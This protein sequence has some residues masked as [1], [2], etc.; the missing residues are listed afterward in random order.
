MIFNILYCAIFALVLIN[1]NGHSVQ[2]AISAEQ[3]QS[4]ETLYSDKDSISIQETIIYDDEKHPLILVQDSAIVKYYMLDGTAID[5]SL[6]NINYNDSIKDLQW[7]VAKSIYNDGEDEYN[8]RELVYILFDSNLVIREVRFLD[9]H[10][11]KPYKQK[12]TKAIKS[13]EK[14]WHAD[15]KSDWYLFRYLQKII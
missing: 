11:N 9:I 8:S 10:T 2:N 5:V 3:N 7:Q 12:L 15:Y 6:G 13:T 4:S 14:N 1:C